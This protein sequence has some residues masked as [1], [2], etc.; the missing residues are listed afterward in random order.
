L[1]GFFCFLE[2]QKFAFVSEEKQKKA[3]RRSAAAERL[4]FN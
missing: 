2:R 1:L 3:S 4:S